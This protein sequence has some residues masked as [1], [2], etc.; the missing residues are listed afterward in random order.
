MEEQRKDQAHDHRRHQA[1]DHPPSRSHQEV[2]EVL[3]HHP[4]PYRAKLRLQPE[5][6]VLQGSR[7]R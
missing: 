2:P 3:R 7:A 1:G 4:G 5:R 6:R